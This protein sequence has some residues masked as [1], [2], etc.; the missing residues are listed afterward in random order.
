MS[1]WHLGVHLPGSAQ[2]A[3]GPA[4]RVAVSISGPNGDQIAMSTA[5]TAQN[6][7]I[8]R[9]FLMPRARLELAPPD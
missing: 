1:R 6:L 4:V 3:A 7:L 2:G 8:S 9:H 5:R